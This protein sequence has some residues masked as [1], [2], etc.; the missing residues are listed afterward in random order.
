M[1]IRNFTGS[2]SVRDSLTQKLI[3]TLKHYVLTPERYFC[4]ETGIEHR[5][6]DHARMV[7]ELLRNSAGPTTDLLRYFPDSLYFDRHR[8]LPTW[9]VEQTRPTTS[10]GAE[11]IHAAQG[12]F[13]FFV[14][15]KYS[16]TPSPRMIQGVPAPFVGQMEREAW[17]TYQRLSG[18]NPAMRNYLGGKR[19]QIALFYA[20]A[21]APDK[22]YAGWEHN[23][24]P[25]R[26]RPDV[27][28]PRE[29]TIRSSRGSGTPWVNFDIR[30][31]KPLEQF[32]V[33]DLFWKRSEAALAVKE[34]R[35]RIDEVAGRDK[36]G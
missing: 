32:L 4:I 5:F 25:I 6:G 7:H 30:D 12:L 20:A 13:T 16:A 10:P 14:E 19:A 9:E 28:R 8:R 2:F 36:K 17:L 22:L 31:L 33:E 24:R 29:K 27:A 11:D 3:A 1:V 15:Y 35:R 18:P 21:Y 23:L 26:I 34:C